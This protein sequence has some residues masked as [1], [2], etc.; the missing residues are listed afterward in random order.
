MGQTDREFM[1]ALRFGSLTRLF[2]PV[3]AIYG[4]ERT[5]KR[6]VL[7]HADLRPG[8][9]VL[10]LGCGSGTLA[11]MAIGRTPGLEI[12][13]LDADPE[14]LASAK[15]KAEQTGTPIR[16]SQGF[17]TQLPHSDDS[18]DAVLSTLFFHHLSDADK[19]TTAE[20]V[21]RVL[22]PGGR[23]VVGDLGS[24]QDPLM[25]LAVASTVQ[26]LDGRA[27]TQLNVDGRLPGVLGRAGLRDV[28]VVDRLR[29]PIGT[30]EVLA[31]KNPQ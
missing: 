20:E 13:G 17:S 10:D 18:F 7:R 1:P 22:K 11:L 19:L 24:P 5:F 23:A 28:A 16:F 26:V 29:T 27:T 25:R 3:I 14:I 31:A 21:A 15:A 8:E 9:R 30:L 2:D 4:R 12:E 6:R